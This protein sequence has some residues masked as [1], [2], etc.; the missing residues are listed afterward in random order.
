MNYQDPSA[1][2]SANASVE[3]LERNC[4]GIHAGWVGFAVIHIILISP[5]VV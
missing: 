5:P 4:P 2:V 1:A 3:L